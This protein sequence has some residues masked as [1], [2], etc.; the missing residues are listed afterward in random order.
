MWGK[1]LKENGCVCMNTEPLCCT[2]EIYNIVYQVYFN[3]T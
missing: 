1:N 2:A 3:K